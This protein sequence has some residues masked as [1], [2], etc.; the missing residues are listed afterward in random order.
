MAED[1]A[2]L[3]DFYSFKSPNT[4]LVLLFYLIDEN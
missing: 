4:Y 2:N 3:Q 1:A